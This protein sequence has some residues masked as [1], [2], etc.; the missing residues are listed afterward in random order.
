M[1]IVSS[2]CLQCHNHG[3]KWQQGI[4]I[5]AD[6]GGQFEADVM[7]CHEKNLVPLGCV[8]SMTLAILDDS[9]EYPE[10]KRDLTALSDLIYART[11]MSK[12]YAW[13]V[14]RNLHTQH[15]R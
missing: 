9:D 7:V 4:D 1:I 15:S 11:R 2:L 12:S 8:T 5:R 3:E 13:P 6:D 10:L 14:S